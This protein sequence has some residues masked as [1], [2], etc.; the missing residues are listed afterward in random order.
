MSLAISRHFAETLDAPHPQRALELEER[1]H[2]IGWAS[3]PRMSDHERELAPRPLN[4]QGTEHDRRRGKSSCAAIWTND[5]RKLRRSTVRMRG[6][7]SKSSWSGSAR[8]FFAITGG[9]CCVSARLRLY[10]EGTDDRSRLVIAGRFPSQ[11]SDGTLSAHRDDLKQNCS[12]DPGERSRASCAKSIDKRQD[13][14]RL[15]IPKP[16]VGALGRTFAQSPDAPWL[17]TC[18]ASQWQTVRTSTAQGMRGAH[19]G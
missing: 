14:L 13:Q 3:H 11:T 2:P 10:A 12:Y 1:N 19:G 17:A 16:D 15:R 18:A 5:R 9:T 6:E 7:A 4:F 8:R